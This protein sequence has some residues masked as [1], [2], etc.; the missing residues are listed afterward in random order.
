[1][2][3]INNLI[4]IIIPIYN[5]IHYVKNILTDVQNQSFTG[6]ECIL[7]DDGSTDGSEVICDQFSEADRRFRVLHISNG[8][9]SHAR[10]T[11][12]DQAQGTYIT[13]LDAD[14]RI[15]PEYLQNLYTC[16]TQSNAD[17]VISGIQ[18]VWSTANRIE[19]ITPPYYGLKTMQDILPT[20][21]RVQQETGIFGYCVAK[22]FHRSLISAHR[23]DEKITLAE[24]LDFY[25]QLYPQI[26]TIYFDNKFYY[27]YLQA[28]EN[29]SML[30]NSDKIDYFTQLKIQKRI[31]AFIQTRGM[32]YGENKQIMNRR[33]YDYVYFTLFH[34]PESDILDLCDKI[35]ELNLEPCL[36]YLN[37]DIRQKWIVALFCSN[38]YGFI[39]ASIRYYRK[40]RFIL[41]KRSWRNHNDQYHYSDL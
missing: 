20:F 17:L 7:V 5:K 33:L 10:N 6:F 36:S 1:M 22:I 21:A 35:K 40:L 19:N 23:F 15:H 13:F 12:I 39:Q 14:D 9:V 32:L 29:S 38:H 41:T 24:D 37:M 30:V 2:H 11:G 31:H 4:T 25:F 28:A 26:K 18:K 16:I 27:Y 3:Y 8:G 34:A